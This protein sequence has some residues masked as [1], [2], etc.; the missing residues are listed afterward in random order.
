MRFLRRIMPMSRRS[1]TA[2]CPAPVDVFG[3]LIKELIQRE[4]DEMNKACFRVRWC[5]GWAEVLP[6]KGY[7]VVRLWFPF[8]D[9]IESVLAQRGIKIPEGWDWGP[10][11][12]R[13]RYL[14]RKRVL[15]IELSKSQANE[16]APFLDMVFKR[17]YDCGDGYVLRGKLDLDFWKNED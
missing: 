16:V 1:G 13:P 5:K 10:L 4:L 14:E 7:L 17:L 9:S 3:A 2:K 12:R 6:R 15:P 11:E 8:K